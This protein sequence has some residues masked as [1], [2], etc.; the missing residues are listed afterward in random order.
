MGEWVKVD[1]KRWYYFDPTLF[2]EQLMASLTRDE[3]IEMWESVKR[4]E[5][6]ANSLDFHNIR[7]QRILAETAKMKEKIQEVIGQME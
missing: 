1:Y 5:R 4:L 7:K 2:E 6:I 3:W